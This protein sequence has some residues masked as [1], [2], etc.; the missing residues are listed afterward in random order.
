MKLDVEH[1][2][3]ENT[4]CSNGDDGDGLIE[5]GGLE[6]L[7]QLFAGNRGE[8]RAATIDALDFALDATA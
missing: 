6:A 7:A 1:L 2:E 4:R 5:I 3:V 8:L